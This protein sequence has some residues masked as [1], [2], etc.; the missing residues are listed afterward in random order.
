MKMIPVREENNGIVL[1]VGSPKAWLTFTCN[2]GSYASK[3]EL[4]ESTACS[5]M[6]LCGEV[7]QKKKPRDSR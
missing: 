2:F 3:I 4:S 1:V 5:N 7:A 6:S